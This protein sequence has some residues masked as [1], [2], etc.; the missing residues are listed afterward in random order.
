MNGKIWRG[1]GSGNYFL[2]SWKKISFK[3]DLIVYLIPPDY[4][5]LLS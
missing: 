1:G 3:A 2:E 4:A 5:A